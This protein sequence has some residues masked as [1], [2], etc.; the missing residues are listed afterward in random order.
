MWIKRKG[1]SDLSLHMRAR[2][3]QVALVLHQGRWSEQTLER[4]STDIH[5]RPSGVP[6]CLWNSGWSRP[7]PCPDT[8]LR[9]IHQQLRP[10]LPQGTLVP[11]LKSGLVGSPAAL[12]VAV[13]EGRQADPL[14]QIGH[15]VDGEINDPS[16][17]A[18]KKQQESLGGT[19]CDDAGEHAAWGPT[20]EPS[21]QA[22]HAGG[23][24]D[25]GY[26]TCGWLKSNRSDRHTGLKSSQATGAKQFRNAPIP[27]SRNRVHKPYR[28]GNPLSGF[29]D[30]MLGSH[31]LIFLRQIWHFRQNGGIMTII[32]SLLSKVLPPNLENPR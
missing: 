22:S 23:G 4:E 24:G 12:L 2:K 25:Q 29:W 1:F 16:Q 15:P 8:H 27:N 13:P 19:A 17:G 31:T 3:S 6:K 28:G 7:G 5:R 10:F 32:A 11:V 30:T 20:Q 14:L 18:W 26:L 9:L 21:G